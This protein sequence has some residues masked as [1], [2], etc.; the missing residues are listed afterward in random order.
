[1]IINILAL[2]SPIFFQLVI[3]KVLVHKGFST[4]QTL[5]VG[6]VVLLCFDAAFNYI[7]QTMLLYATNKIDMRLTRRTFNHLLYLPT[8]FFD[9]NSA[10][11]LLKHMQQTEKIRGFL[12][13]RLLFTLLDLSVLIVVIPIIFMYSVSLSFIVLGTAL[14]IAII[15]AFAIPIFRK[16]LMDLYMDGKLRVVSEDAY[17]A[18]SGENGQKVPTFQARVELTNTSLHDVAKDTRFLPG[19]TL[20]AEIVVGDRRVISF[21]AYPLIRGLDESLREP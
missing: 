20:T 15:L 19:M 16:R 8:D 12:T 7:K 11:V 9:S 17:V 18:N 5:A 3:D 21:L 13:G 10:G 14:V 2:G 4:L 1:M 6:M